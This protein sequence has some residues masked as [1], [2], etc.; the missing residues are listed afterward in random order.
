MRNGPEDLDADP[1]VELRWVFWHEMTEKLPK[2]LGVV[3]PANRPGLRAILGRDRLL[4]RAGSG[5]R[6]AASQP[7]RTQL[8]VAALCARWLVAGPLTS[9]P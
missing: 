7:T 4:A 3:H 1:S 9:Q 2:T 5:A 6:I 8:G